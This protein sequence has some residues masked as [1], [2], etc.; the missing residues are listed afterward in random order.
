MAKRASTTLQMVISVTVVCVVAAAGL[1]VTY[2][3]T[4]DRIAV[5][6]KLAE[7]RALRVVL[8]DGEEFVVVPEVLDDAVVAAGDTPV[9]GVYKAT[10]ASGD[11]VGWGVRTGPRG[12]GGPIQMVV[13]LDRDG[14]VT[15]VSII[16]MNETPGLGT[17]V[18]T[19]AWFLEQFPGLDSA[20]ADKTIRELD[21]ITGATKSSRGIRNGV[22]AAT[23][24]HVDV[25]SG[26]GVGQ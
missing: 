24:V 6:E 4:K 22:E 14:K 12:Y 8:P 1:S 16:T 15:G 19:E 21:T 23:A 20:T 9:S 26:E 25:L 11:V 2:A 7:E 5:Q 3:V 17:R 13:G 18:L 10:D